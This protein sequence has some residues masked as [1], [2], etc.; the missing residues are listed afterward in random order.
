[1]KICNKRKLMDCCF[2]FQ[3]SQNWFSGGQQKVVTALITVSPQ[4]GSMLAA[5]ATPALVP[6]PNQIPTIHWV[7]PI[8][9]TVSMILFVAFVRTSLP[10]TP[11]SRSAEI[12]NV[13]VTLI[14]RC[15][16]YRGVSFKLVVCWSIPGAVNGI[17]HNFYFFYQF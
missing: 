13:K 8:V 11:P 9:P 1:M 6:T 10:P 5:A 7:W 3:I 12:G 16:A 15:F 14:K 4:L 2:H 17:C